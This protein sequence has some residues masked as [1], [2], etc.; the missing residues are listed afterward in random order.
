MI[1]AQASDSH[2]SDHELVVEYIK[3]FLRSKECGDWI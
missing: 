2:T 3:I 1:I